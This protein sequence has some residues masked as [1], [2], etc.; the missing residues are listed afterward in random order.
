MCCP[1]RAPR[2]VSARWFPPPRGDGDFLTSSVLCPQRSAFCR[3]PSPPLIGLCVDMFSSNHRGPKASYFI[4]WGCNPWLSLSLTLSLCPGQTA[5]CAP[6]RKRHSGLTRTLIGS[7]GPWGQ[8]SCS[9]PGRAYDLG[10]VGEHRGVPVHPDVRRKGWDRLFFKALFPSHQSPTKAPCA[11]SQALCCLPVET[12]SWL[13]AVPGGQPSP[14][15]CRSGD[16]GRLL[17]IHPAHLASLWRFSSRAFP[18]QSPACL[19]SLVTKH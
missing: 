13:W 11:P 3:E 8:G 2:W 16:T 5:G 7:C 15:T 18:P 6:G 19:F 1:L 10:H 4:R 17:R 12:R 9:R 14:V